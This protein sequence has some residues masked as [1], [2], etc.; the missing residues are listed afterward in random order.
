MQINS[1]YLKL[2][3]NCATVL[4]ASALLLLSQ[5]CSR[6]PEHEPSV[7][8]DVEAAVYVARFA[9]ESTERGN[10]VAITDL[11]VEF[12]EVQ[13]TARGECQVALGETPVVTLSRDAWERSTDAERE[14]LVFHELGHCLLGLAHETGITP[15]GIPRSVMS[16]TEISGHIYKQYRDYYLQG[17]FRR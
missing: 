2:S 6:A 5:G 8:I 11:I 16:P 1:V 17:L 15:D 9:S 13:G 3:R 4:G 10:A 12:G 14:E 7:Q